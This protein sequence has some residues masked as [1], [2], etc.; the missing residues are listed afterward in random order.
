M[1]HHKV[2]A[3]KS[4]RNLKVEDQ[5]LARYASRAKEAG[6]SEE[7]SK[8]I[9]M[10]LIRESVEAQLRIPQVV[11]PKKITIVGGS[12]KMGAWF[13][14]F[15]AQRGHEI[16]VNDIISSTV[17][18]FENNL[19]RAIKHSD[20][21]VVAAPISDSPAILK[22]VLDLKPKG[23]VFDLSSIKEPVI[24]LLRN[25]VEKGERV[26]SVH[27]MFG[28]EA[29]SMLERNLLLC[30]CGS[31]EAIKETKELF[32]SAGA[33]IS[34][35]PI[36]THDELIAYVLGMSHALNIAFFD[37]LGKSGHSFEELKI[38]ASTTFNDQVVN[39]R[40]V[41]KEDPEMYYEI[42]HLNPHN[43]VALDKLLKAMEEVRSAAKEK[44][45]DEF[46]HI[47]KKGKEYFGG[48]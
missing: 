4:I 10:L 45:S 18:P 13:S 27:P 40:R 9:A 28:P 24:K 26:C 25:A 38:A 6:I 35:I 22:S 15:F 19:R 37:A 8:Q 17:F 31:P 29:V 20:I 30:D 7:I 47:M 34:V 41:A 3:N 1:G 11:E 46:N 2:D 21:V 42:Q 5:V 14:R 44:D 32:T 12:G 36:E 23:L 48:K 43:V 16:L 39:S 33:N